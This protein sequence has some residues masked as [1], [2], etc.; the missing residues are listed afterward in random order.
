MDLDSN[1]GSTT[2]YVILSKWLNLYKLYIPHQ[3]TGI[4]PTSQSCCEISEVCGI[5]LSTFIED[6]LSASHCSKV[7]PIVNMDKTLAITARATCSL[8]HPQGPRLQQSV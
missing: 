7:K 1:P 4:I 2:Y 8:L 3:N 5:I 6:L